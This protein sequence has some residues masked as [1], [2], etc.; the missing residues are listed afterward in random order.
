MRGLI[1]ILSLY[2]TLSLAAQ[3]DFLMVGD[4]GWTFD[5][6]N[7]FKNFDVIDAYVGNLT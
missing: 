6:N 2:S 5:M 3:L 7:S 1:I 4:F